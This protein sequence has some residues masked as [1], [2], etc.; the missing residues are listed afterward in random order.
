VLGPGVY[1]GGVDQPKRA[2]QR[3]AQAAE[4]LRQHL[5]GILGEGDVGRWPSHLLAQQL[6]DLVG[7][8]ELVELAHPFLKALGDR[9]VLRRD[10]IPLVPFGRVASGDG[11][12]VDLLVDKLAETPHVVLVDFDARDRAEEAFEHR[13]S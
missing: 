4:Q 3:D 7:L 6:A 13:D 10:H 12:G 8:L 9:Q 5:L 11:D 2:G 1:Q